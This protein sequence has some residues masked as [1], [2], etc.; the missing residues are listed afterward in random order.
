MAYVTLFQSP[1]V[2]LP[3]IVYTHTSSLIFST[4]TGISHTEDLRDNMKFPNL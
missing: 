1:L 4:S 2:F 3:S